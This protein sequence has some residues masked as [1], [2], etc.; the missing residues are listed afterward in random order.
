[1][2]TLKKIPLFA[3]L[4][5]LAHSAPALDRTNETFKVF[6]FPP[7]MIPTIDGMTNDWNI[8]PENYVLG[9]DQLVDDMHNQ[10]NNPKHLNVRV[11]VGWVKGL[12]RLYFLYEADKD[13]W[14]FSRPDLH[15]DI[16]EIVVDGDLSG[17]PFEQEFETNLSILGRWNTYM[18]LQN[19]HAQNY[20][21]FTPAEGKDWCMFWGPQQ[22]VKDLPYANHACTY[23]FKPG[24]PGHLVLEFWITPFDYAGLEG[25]RRAVE[26]VL[27]EN[28]IIGLSWAVID[29]MD[30]NS[31]GNNG[32][33]NLSRHHT[34]FGNADYL[35]PFKLMPLEPQFLKPLDA[36]WTFQIVDMDRRLVAF[37][38]LSIGKITSW[39]WEFGDSETSA[40]QNPIHTY[41]AAGAYTVVLNVEGPAGK[42]RFSRVWDVS[43]K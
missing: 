11:R 30:P 27:T 5:L 31:R 41:K 4:L 6:Q 2:N 25:P 22:W 36:Q 14:D 29:Y 21:I 19:S 7:N 20:H 42:A 26:S 16:F 9:S 10:T 32:F 40:E 33:W 13:Y 28:K 38:D 39:K 15:N 23:N 12:N 37:K 43:L 17:G 35:C 1:M 8:V 3:A 34:F 24:E 18:T